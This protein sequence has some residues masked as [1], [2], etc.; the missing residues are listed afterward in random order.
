MH[1]LWAI[2]FGLSPLPLVAGTNHML[3]KELFH[4]PRSSAMA[5]AGF[6]LD[7]TI[8]AP[9]LN[10]AGIGGLYWEVSPF[11]GKL[12]FP[13]PYLG[14]GSTDSSL[15]Q[16]TEVLDIIINPSL[17]KKDSFLATTPEKN[18]S[19]HRGM[20]TNLTIKRFQLT[21]FLNDEFNGF[22]GEDTTTPTNPESYEIIYQKS[23]GFLGGMAIPL[24][25]SLNVGISGGYQQMSLAQQT[26]TSKADLI[27]AKQQQ[28]LFEGGFHKYEG[29][30]VNMGIHYRFLARKKGLSPSLALAVQDVGNTT[31][32]QTSST[33]TP[34]DINTPYKQATE[35]NYIRTQNIS[36]GASLSALGAF[37]W[38]HPHISVAINHIGNEDVDFEDSLAIGL[39]LD[40][41]EPGEGALLR[42]SGGV[43]SYKKGLSLTV[44]LGLVG[45]TASISKYALG[46]DD[47]TE[48]S[49]LVF[50]NL[51]SITESKGNKYLKTK[52]FDFSTWVP[53]LFAP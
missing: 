17:D 5:G 2:L 41:G 50:T 38:F 43:S 28:S 14:G 3:K 6:I 47:L 39:E 21:A 33:D 4:T 7:D 8:S 20:I 35:N 45:A 36:L 40:M 19:V 51:A 25:P 48:S 16:P 18:F 26:F 32:D 1:L 27:G 42:I 52:K 13:G 12:N 23:T 24:T 34:M 9:E 22:S 37:D 11:L 15:H 31:F 29:S 53:T 46:Q 30:F 44:D 49:I 10:P